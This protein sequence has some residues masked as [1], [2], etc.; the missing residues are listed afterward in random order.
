M[1]KRDQKLERD[2]DVEVMDAML[3]DP[4][5]N[6]TFRGVIHTDYEVDSIRA[7]WVLE[8]QLFLDHV[9]DKEPTIPYLKE[10]YNLK[11]PVQFIREV[12][13]FDTGQR[14]TKTQR[15]S[16]NKLREKARKAEKYSNRVL[17]AATEVNLQLK[18]REA[19]QRLAAL[20][21]KYNSL[22]FRGQR[23]KNDK[24]KIELIF[25]D[26]NGK[27]NLHTFNTYQDALLF[28][29]G[30]MQGHAV[31][32]QKELQKWETKVLYELQRRNNREG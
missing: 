30:F 14:M 12:C 10:R 13:N 7:L 24:G 20:L 22:G 19:Q 23:S 2:I 27:T 28:L 9:T 29:I 16:I 6:P 5:Y 3:N 31:A 18:G 25:P 17:E 4:D 32:T 15:G 21:S 26:I 1:R 8:N 11:Q